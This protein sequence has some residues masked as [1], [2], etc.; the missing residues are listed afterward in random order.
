MVKGCQISVPASM[1]HEKKVLR[2]FLNQRVAVQLP[3]DEEKFG[4]FQVSTLY[5]KPYSL[6]GLKPVKFEYEDHECYN[7]DEAYAAWYSRGRRSSRFPLSI[8]LLSCQSCDHYVVNLLMISNEFTVRDRKNYR[9]GFLE[10]LIRQLIYRGLLAV[11]W[12]RRR[13]DGL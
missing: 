5:Y 10:Q 7:W 8:L 4:W 11:G 13:Y 3:R 1:V 12:V 9:G 6:V 2:P